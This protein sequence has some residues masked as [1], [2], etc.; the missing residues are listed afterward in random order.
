MKDE[1]EWLGA[2]SDRTQAARSG[3]NIKQNS[4]LSLTCD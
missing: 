3:M 1:S 4:T 2:M